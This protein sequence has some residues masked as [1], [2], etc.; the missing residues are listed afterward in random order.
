MLPRET[1]RYA[2]AAL[3]SST[4]IAFVSFIIFLTLLL[5]IKKGS[6]HGFDVAVSEPFVLYSPMTLTNC[7]LASSC[8]A[9]QAFPGQP[10]KLITRRI[11]RASAMY[12]ASL[13][14]FSD[15]SNTEKKVQY[16]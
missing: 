3:V 14:R 10:R 8:P 15:L 4:P 5:L 12:T 13:D 7:H 16:R 11:G 2:A 1:P 6:K 9:F